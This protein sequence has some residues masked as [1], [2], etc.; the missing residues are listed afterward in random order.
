MKKKSVLSPGLPG[1]A[2]HG[3]QEGVDNGSTSMAFT[4]TSEGTNPEGF[5]VRMAAAVTVGQNVS[6]ETRV[7]E[8]RISE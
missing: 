2:F 7:N 4:I 6:H 8:I 3:D 5:V 1:R